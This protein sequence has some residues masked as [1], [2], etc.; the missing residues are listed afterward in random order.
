MSKEGVSTLADRKL[1][2]CYGNVNCPR[3]GGDGSYVKSVNGP[4][5]AGLRAGRSKIKKLS[6]DVERRNA[7]KLTN[8]ILA[9]EIR[10]CPLCDARLFRNDL[11]AHLRRFH[12]TSKSRNGCFSRM[13]PEQW[14]KQLIDAG[15]IK[16]K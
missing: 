4:M 7:V 11:D 15:I 10:N 9:S 1:C 5:N 6:P 8:S 2:T 3:C 16:P 14:R 13:S 12:R